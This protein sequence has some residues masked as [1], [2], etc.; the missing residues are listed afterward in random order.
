MSSSLMEY[1]WKHLAHYQ[2]DTRA[3]TVRGCTWVIVDDVGVDQA[4]SNLIHSH[5]ACPV[6]LGCHGGHRGD[7]QIWQ[8]WRVSVNSPTK[9]IRSWSTVHFMSVGWWW[10]TV[11]VPGWAWVIEWVQR[12][13][14]YPASSHLLLLDTD[15]L[16]A[17]CKDGGAEWHPPLCC[18]IPPSLVSQSI[19]VSV[20]VCLC[21][22]AFMSLRTTS[23]PQVTCKLLG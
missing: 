7:G 12:M 2:V 3:C 9:W 14:N 13:K 6:N 11:P 16:S 1:L 22:S 17:S 23:K 4:F 19:V 18:S 5:P 10:S 21:L 20:L 8:P 15:D